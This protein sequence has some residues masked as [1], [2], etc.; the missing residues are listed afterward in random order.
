MSWE[1][2]EGYRPRPRKPANGIRAQSQRGRFG[3][4][5]WAGRW[6]AALER[7]CNAGRLARG[8]SYARSGQVVKLD[9]GTDGVKAAVQ[10]SR[11]RPYG[12]GIRFRTLSDAEWERVIDA[13]AGQ[14]L[15]AAKLL[16][17]EM[18]EEIE[19]V[20]TQAGVSLL[21][22]T[23]EDLLTDCSCPDWANP[24]KHV[25]AV[26]YLL[27]ERFDA[28]PFLMFELRGRGKDALLAALRERRG[29]AAGDVGAGAEEAPEEQDAAPLTALSPAAFWSSPAGAPSL[30]FAFDPPPIDALA[31]KRLGTPPFWTQGGWKDG[32]D[33]D[34]AMEQVYRT[35]G[36]QA[37]RLAM[38][39]E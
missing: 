2:W 5:W 29:G 13:M 11:A 14:A 7:L 10:G 21:P 35:I 24:C 9:A 27:G 4:S 28:D 38:G 16:A 19:E 15:Y 25:A 32:R 6:I 39:P 30:A 20:F 22:A 23:D 17:G 18:P 37:R 3:A 33:F 8:R 26:H 36:D 34:A 12:V 1:Y 31:A